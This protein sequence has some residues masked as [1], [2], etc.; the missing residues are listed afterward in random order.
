MKILKLTCCKLAVVL[1]GVAA[2][3]SQGA[4]SSTSLALPLADRTVTAPVLN[5]NLLTPPVPS[6]IWRDEVGNGFRK[7]AMEVGATVGASLGS[8]IFGSTD[9]HDLGLVKLSVGRVISDVVN[10]DSWYSGNWELLGEVFGGEQF[11]PHNAHLDGLTAILRYDFATGTK[12]V[13]F[14]DAGGGVTYSDI[15]HP[16]LG[17]N[18]QFNLQ[19]GPGMNWFIYK[20]IA[21]TVQY[22]FLHLSSGGMEKPN[23]GVNTSAF[24]AGISWFF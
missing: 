3:S 19:T 12:W 21:L 9:A 16:D 23:H 7:G 13:P 4:E 20:N 5:T 2:D 6:S 17:G 10:S 24:Y 1:A 11:K 15:G 22:R 8:Q 18:C 14:F